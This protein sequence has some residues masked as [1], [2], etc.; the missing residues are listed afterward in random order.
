VRF[1]KGLAPQPGVAL[2]AFGT[3]GVGGPARWFV[4]AEQPDEVAAARA[5]CEEQGLSWFILG[6]GSNVVIADRGFDGLVVQIGI[7]GTALSC[8][9]D[10]SLITAGAGE[11]WD[12]FVSMAVERGLAGVEC[13]SGI[14]GTVGG[15]PIQNVGAY[16]Q[17][18]SNT[19][20]RVEVYD[21]EEHVLRTLSAA[22]CGFAYR[23]SRFKTAD[24]GRF[25]VCAVTFRLRP[26]APNTTYPDVAR[27]LRQAGAARPGLDDV[28][29]AVL[30]IRRSKGMVVHPDD[31]DSRSVGS[32]FVNPAVSVA[33]RERI[34]ATAG[35]VPPG[36]PADDGRVKIPAAWLIERSGFRKGHIAGAAGIS[37]RHP[38]AL[39]NRGGATAADIVRLARAVKQAVGDRF[40]VWLKPEPVFVGFEDD[41]D[42]AFLTR[43][44]D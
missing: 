40:G 11:S 14:P 1:S 8:D 44:Q 18:V 37:T 19:I 27:H 31:P 4:R 2:A 41:D 6:G 38:L 13:M 26:G 39:V 32:F 33:D 16:G 42:V 23:T 28:R 12:G 21:C 3:L 25:V 43:A 10:D 35:E 22:E 29:E 9:G 36:F 30:T 17:E 5:W 20:E 34:A 15:T 7:R 24:A